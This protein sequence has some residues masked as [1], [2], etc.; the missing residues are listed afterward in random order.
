MHRIARITVVFLIFFA[1][2]AQAQTPRASTRHDTVSVP[3]TA[4]F[5]MTKSPLVAILLSA[6]LPG[7]GQVYL[8]QSWKLPILYG[9]IAG[10]GYGVYIQNSRYHQYLDSSVADY[11]AKTL[12]D[13]SNAI[14]NNERWEFYQND[15]DKWWI[16]LGITYIANILDAYISA[17]LYDFDVSNPAPSGFESFYDPRSG[18]MGLSFTMHF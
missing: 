10:F 14:V 13:S 5:H 7:A 9:L 3:D 1:W 11:A 18:Q 6:V 17:N 8:G 16:F 15:R 4:A 12:F 2:A